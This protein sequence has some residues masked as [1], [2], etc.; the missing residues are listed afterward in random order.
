MGAVMRAFALDEF[1]KPGSVREV[2]TPD[3]EEGQ[4]RVKVRAAGINPFD[5]VV[6]TGVMKDRMEHHFPLIPAA[7]LSGTIDAV[8]S[9]VDQWKV[10]D[11]VFGL[12][13]KMSIGRGSLAEFATAS[14]ATI[15]RRPAAVDAE[16]GAALP[17]AGV[18]AL[19]CVEPMSLRTGDVVVIV[20]AAGGIGGFAVQLA[21]H[22]G[23]T[24]IAVTRGVNADYVRGLGADEVV[25]YTS[26][27]VAA[28]VGRAHPQ[29]IDGVIHLAGD[30]QT[31]AGLAA[32]VSE[33]GQVASM[34]GGAKVEDLAARGVTGMNVRTMVNTAALEKLAAM[35]VAGALKRPQ[36][37]AFTLEES[38]AAFAEIGT[39]H[40]RG[41]LVVVP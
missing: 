29:G 31:M 7:D 22:A 26:Q 11:E 9:G 39:G 14:A 1:G 40:V 23:A 17:L 27:D 3:A 33:G 18:S 36:I 37:K 21:K 24:V 12:V 20:G 28:T 25:D 19:M 34:I 35:V 6:L 16:L 8:G 10:G 2:P 13:G 15:G 32:I 5:N 41:K 30:A 4:V 38:G